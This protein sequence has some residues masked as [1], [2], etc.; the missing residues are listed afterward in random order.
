MIVEPTCCQSRSAVAAQRQ[1][2]ACRRRAPKEALLRLVRA[3]S[4]EVVADL[5]AR[6]P[7]RGAYC[8]VRRSCLERG[9]TPA[10]LGR[11]FRGRVKPVATGEWLTSLHRQACRAVHELL[12]IYSKGGVA[13]SGAERLKATLAKEPSPSGMLLL[14][15]DAGRSTAGQWLSWAAKNQ[16]KGRQAMTAVDLG[17]ALGKAACSVVW[18]SNR[19]AA[20]RVEW[21]LDLVEELAEN[22]GE[23]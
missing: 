9:I 3:P 14:A 4:G 12:G 23:G 18:V 5:Q 13:V 22:S 6:L 11:A 19:G 1:C 2:I 8:C 7:G 21:Y 17:Q 15:G 10:T 20:A 16:I